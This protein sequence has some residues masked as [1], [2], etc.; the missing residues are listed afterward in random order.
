MIIIKPKLVRMKQFKPVY[1]PSVK[2]IFTRRGFLNSTSS[3]EFCNTFSRNPQEVFDS[4][5][6]QFN[7]WQYEEYAKAKAAEEAAKAAE[8]A[9][10]QQAH[11]D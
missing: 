11:A 9:A 8:D 6:K 4:T 7:Q 3:K 2:Q 5:S 1:I 10:A